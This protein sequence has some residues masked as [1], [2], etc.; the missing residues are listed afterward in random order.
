MG[1]KLLLAVSICA[2]AA[3]VVYAAVNIRGMEPG[4][5]GAA[6]DLPQSAGVSR[7]GPAAAAGERLEG[8]GDGM[9]ALR[10]AAE[11]DKYAFAF[12][13]K[14]EDEG[15]QEMR[16][17]FETA[18]E[19]VTDRAEHVILN[20]AD[21]SEKDMIEKYGIDRSPMPLVLAFAPNG[22]LTRGLP[23]SFTEEQIMSCFVSPCME[24]CLK[25]V[26]D[27]RLVAVCVQNGSTRFNEEAMA[28][29]RAFMTDP[30]FARMT[31]LVMLDPSDP[32]EATTCKRFSVD[33]DTDQAITLLLAPPGNIIGRFKG[34]TDKDDMVSILT[35][36]TSGGCGPGSG[37]GCCP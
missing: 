5:A 21:P 11:E 14:D 26:Q 28:G 35:R 34:A 23:R 31:D 18:M 1:K 37:S 19:K 33:P 30:R 12:F 9:A 2:V 16:E 25:G 27:S 13:Y 29:V 17:L 36:A 32:D 20:A 10:D 3:F 7:E 4:S 8:S 22:A 15:T 24:M 6:A